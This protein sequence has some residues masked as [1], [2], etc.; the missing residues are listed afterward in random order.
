VISRV[1]LFYVGS[2]L[3]VVAIVPWDSKGIVTPYVQAL[4]A[5]GWPARPILMNAVS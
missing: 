5:I 1:L 2:I 4:S 3:L